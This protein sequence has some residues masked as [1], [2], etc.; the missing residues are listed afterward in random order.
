MYAHVST[1]PKKT[2]FPLLAALHSSP[3]HIFEDAFSTS[4]FLNGVDFCHEEQLTLLCVHLTEQVHMER[5]K[6]TQNVPT[7]HKTVE[8]RIANEMNFWVFFFFHRKEREKKKKLEDGCLVL[9]GTVVGVDASRHDALDEH[10]LGHLG[11]HVSVGKL[12]RHEYT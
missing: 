4:V 11:A 8:A 9:L 3:R 10:L 5:D 7:Q 2:L 1:V 12:L 6:N